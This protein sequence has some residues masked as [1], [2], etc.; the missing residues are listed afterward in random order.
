MFALQNYQNILISYTCVADREEKM[1]KEAAADLLAVVQEKHMESC[2]EILLAR[3]T[4][5]QV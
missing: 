2:D 3:V 1:M 5:R 4:V